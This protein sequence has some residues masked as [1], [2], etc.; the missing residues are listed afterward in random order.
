MKILMKSCFDISTVKS[1]FVFQNPDFFDHYFVDY[2]LAMPMQLYLYE[3]NGQDIDNVF[4]WNPNDKQWWIT[5]WNPKYVNKVDVKKT[6]SV[7]CVDFVGHEDMYN[8]LKANI[9]NQ[10]KIKDYMIFDDRSVKAW[11]CWNG[12]N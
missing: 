7:G 4:S 2:D 3:C 11:L 10:K 6:V 8:A 1:E 9:S 5:G 12:V